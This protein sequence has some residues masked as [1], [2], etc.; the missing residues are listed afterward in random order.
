MDRLSEKL[1]ALGERADAEVKRRPLPQALERRVKRQRLAIVGSVSAL[2]ALSVVTSGWFLLRSERPSEVVAKAE[3]VTAGSVREI[4]ERYV[5]YVEDHEVF[6][7]T[8]GDKFIGLSAWSPIEDDEGDRQRMLFCTLSNLFESA[9]GPTYTRTGTR[10]DEF[11]RE[12]MSSVAVR[13]RD[14]VVEIAPERISTNDSDPFS[15]A[16][17]PP[18]GEWGPVVEGPPGFALAS[19]APPEEI[20]ASLQPAQVEVGQH[21]KLRFAPGHTSGLRWDVFRFDGDV[22]L[23]HGILVAGPGYTSRFG[24]VPLA[25]EVGGIDDIGFGGSYAMNLKIPEL[26]PGKYRLATYALRGGKKPSEER[27]VWH[28]ADFEVTE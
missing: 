27:E 26:Q 23:W 28:Y 24:I 3:W 17:G 2:I 20:K 16:A 21:A 12:R 11:S 15:G 1:R 13:T 6:V 7:L 18:C 14:G 25:E 5:V 8:M 19:E 10:L 9:D 4:R 22:W